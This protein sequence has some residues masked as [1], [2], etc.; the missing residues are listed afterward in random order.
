MDISVEIL[1]TSVPIKKENLHYKLK[2]WWA[3]VDVKEHNSSVIPI[4]TLPMIQ[5]FY[6]MNGRETT[7]FVEM[8]YSNPDLFPVGAMRFLG[9]AKQ[10]V[11]NQLR[12][13][14]WNP[15]VE[16]TVTIIALLINTVLF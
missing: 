7:V 4:P 5:P 1:A 15:T 6:D 11:D 2:T 3:H 12:N 13:P 8:W 14:A 16:V 10:R 9:L